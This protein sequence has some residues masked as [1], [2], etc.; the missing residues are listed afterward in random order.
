MPN[1][2]RHSD[3]RLLD[4]LAHHSRSGF[5]LFHFDVQAPNHGPMPVSLLRSLSPMPPQAQ[6]EDWDALRARIDE[7]IEKLKADRA[8]HERPRDLLNWL[9]TELN[10][11]DKAHKP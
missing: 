10:S 1:R 8:E 5:Y 4:L 3:A 2:F 11:G 6:S 9:L 7:L